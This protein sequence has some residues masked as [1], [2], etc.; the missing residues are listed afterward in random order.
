MLFYIYENKIFCFI[1]TINQIESLK[2]FDV[3]F[4]LEIKN[5]SKVANEL[6]N[7]NPFLKFQGGGS[8]CRQVSIYQSF[9]FQVFEQTKKDARDQFQLPSSNKIG[10]SYD[11]KSINDKRQMYRK[12]RSFVQLV[13]LCILFL[14]TK[15]WYSK[16]KSSR[17]T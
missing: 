13:F 11:F 1:V 4:K 3:L 6:S 17:I 12:Y 7:L 14:L 15:C 9:F 8:P 10:N 16:P 2:M 5:Y